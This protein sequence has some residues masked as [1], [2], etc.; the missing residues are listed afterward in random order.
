MAPPPIILKLVKVLQTVFSTIEDPLVLKKYTTDS[1]TAGSNFVLYADPAIPTGV[2]D[3]GTQTAIDIQTAVDAHTLSPTDVNEK[4]IT[5]AMVKAKAWLKKYSELVEPIA[6]SNDNRT[7][8]EEAAINIG[9]SF[10]TPQKLENTKGGDPET[11]VF[12]VKNL[13]DDGIGVQ[14]INGETYSPTRTILIAVELPPSNT[15]VT[16]DPEV[17]I[18]GGQPKITFGGWAGDIYFDVASG[19]GRVCKIPVSKTG[20][21]YAVYGLAQNGNKHSSKISKPVIV[22]M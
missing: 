20:V 18:V 12:T 2:Y 19:K 11:P 22:K 15:D 5:A 10:L 4:A 21:R 13:G 3:D 16:P 9:R 8:R 6:N 1:V 17:T 7:T 14:I